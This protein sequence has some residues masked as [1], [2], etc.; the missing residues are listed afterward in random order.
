LGTFM[1]K[2]VRGSLTEEQQ[3]LLDESLQKEI[4]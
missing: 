4:H 1:R 3:K 2:M